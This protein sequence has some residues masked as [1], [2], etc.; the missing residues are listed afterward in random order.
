MLPVPDDVMGQIR[1]LFSE[2]PELGYVDA[3]EFARD[4]IRR[5]IQQFKK[6]G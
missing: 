5:F 4:A 3:D 2:R 6:D 1:E